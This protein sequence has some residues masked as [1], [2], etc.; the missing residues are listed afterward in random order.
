MIRRA[1]AAL[2]MLLVISACTRV[3]TSS[4]GGGRHPYTHPHE[5]RFTASE[6]L[7]GLNPLVNDQATLLYLSTMTM[8]YLIRTDAHSEATV[9]ELCTVIP[10]K[11]NGG[12]SA[13]GKT[14]TYHL[15]HNVKMVG[16]RAVLRRRRR[17]LDDRRAR[18]A[19]EHR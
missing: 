4:E 2:G 19:H 16:R 14:L 18:S 6:D 1:L 5:L 3:G 13:D 17:V 15:R 11:A 8:A 10:S 9:P 7:V 12:I